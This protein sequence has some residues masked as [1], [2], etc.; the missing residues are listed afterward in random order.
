MKTAMI[1]VTVTMQA[2][3]NGVKKKSLKKRKR[4]WMKRTKAEIAAWE[5]QYGTKKGDWKHAWQTAGFQKAPSLT[6]RSIKAAMANV[7]EKMKYDRQV[8][9]QEIY[10]I[11][12]AQFRED[13]DWSKLA[14][15]LVPM[16]VAIA[17]G[18]LKPLPGQGKALETIMLRGFGR[19]SAVQEEREVPGMIVIPALDTDE[20]K[21]ICG[22]CREVIAKQEDDEDPLGTEPRSAN[23]ILIDNS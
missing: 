5:Y 19:V 15:A 13:K 16:Q 17:T 14:E 11:A 3:P 7:A 9:L 23:D 6:E 12:L 10:Q 4:L 20:Q 2:R 22:A 8:E 1:A 18:D 21:H